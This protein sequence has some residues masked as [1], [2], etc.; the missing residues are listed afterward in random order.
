MTGVQTCALPICFPVT[1]I[2]RINIPKP[3]PL[4]QIYSALTQIIEDTNEV[5]VDKYGR[6]GHLVNI[7]EY[8]L[9]QPSELNNKH[10]SIF[11]R[12][13][14]IDYKHSMIHIDVRPNIEAEK[15]IQNIVGD[16]NVV[17]EDKKHGEKYKILDE[18]N[19]NYDLTVKYTD[20][21]VKIER[22]DNNWYKH[23]GVTINKMVN[24]GTISKME[25]D[26]F[27][28]EHIVD[29]LLFEEKVAVL[30]IL[31]SKSIDALSEF[32]RKVKTYLDKMIIE[33]KRFKAIILYSSKKQNI[34]IFNAEKQKWQDAEGEDEV[35]VNEKAREM[36]VKPSYNSIIGFIDYE[37]KGQFLV[38][39]YKY[40][41]KERNTGARCDNA[42]KKVK[43]QTL[44]D[45]VG[46]TMYD[47][48]NTNRIN[49]SE[50]CSLQEFLL[51]KYNKDRKNGNTWFLSMEMFKLFEE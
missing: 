36:F 20:E 49:E 31:Y 43:I 16:I 11:E 44:N 37:K 7:G 21:N 4:V 51:R 1:I 40:T 3:Y 34:M 15:Q 35:V 42:N 45:I 2:K 22:G 12:A 6:T 23:C 41:D 27:L 33:T 10:I 13:V 39:K 28:I 9:F 32:E 5:V 47:E 48:K 17:S 25:G 24:Q 38:F 30:N 50:L 46:Q 26:E 19:A 18:M 14:P 8:Y 29:M